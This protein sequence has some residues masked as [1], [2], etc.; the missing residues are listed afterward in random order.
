VHYI[1]PIDVPS[2]G[3]PLPTVV[4]V[5]GT[6]VPF[7]AEDARLQFRNSYYWDKKAMKAGPDDI[8]VAKI[9]AGLRMRPT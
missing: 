7:V 1:E 8:K 9:I 5:G 4:N 2:F 6:N 3:P